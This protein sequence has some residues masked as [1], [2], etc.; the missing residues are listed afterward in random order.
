MIYGAHIFHVF[1]RTAEPRLDLRRLLPTLPVK[2][3]VLRETIQ[4]LLQQ[5]V[6]QVLQPDILFLIQPA[7]AE[8]T[9]YLLYLHRKKGRRG[10]LRRVILRI[11]SP[12]K[13]LITMVCL[14]HYGKDNAALCVA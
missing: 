4:P 6:Y 1:P 7:G 5:S 11:L 8:Q 2:D 10:Y 14:F 13:I 3:L 12:C 9:P